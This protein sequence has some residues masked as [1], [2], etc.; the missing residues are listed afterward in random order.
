MGGEGSGD[1]PGHEF[2]GNQYGYGK[3]PERSVLPVPKF[4][5]SAPYARLRVEGA[6]HTNEDYTRNWEKAKDKWNER[7]FKAESI[8]DEEEYAVHKAYAGNVHAWDLNR[9]LRRGEYD[10]T[11]R[12]PAKMNITINNIKN[13]ITKQPTMPKGEELWRGVQETNAEEGKK[14]VVGDVVADKGFTSTTYDLDHAQTF[15]DGD[16]SRYEVLYRIVT[17]GKERAIPGSESESEMIFQAGQKWEVT[18]IDEVFVD[19]MDPD[20][21]VKHPDDTRPPVRYRIITVT[22]VD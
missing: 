12:D 2:H 22:G 11:L 16:S 21:G 1:R 15:C 10:A 13:A 7:D 20:L 17:S 18:G 4:H 19:Y 8:S 5:K 14:L 3:S 6:G 9:Y